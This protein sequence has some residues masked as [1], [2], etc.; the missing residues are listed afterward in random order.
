MHISLS[1]A[2][3]R[4]ASPAN[5]PQTGIQCPQS[6]FFLSSVAGKQQGVLNL[7]DS[8]VKCSWE[9]GNTQQ[10]N[11]YGKVKVYKAQL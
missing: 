7:K 4:V 6:H 9:T 1:K 2:A 3:T 10:N 8:I 5:L 11:E